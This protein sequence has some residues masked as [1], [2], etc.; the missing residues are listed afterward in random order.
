MSGSSSAAEYRSAYD[1]LLRRENIPG[2]R[3]ASGKR[4]RIRLGSAAPGGKT[5]TI[6][7]AQ[8]ITAHRGTHMTDSLHAC[9]FVPDGWHT[10][11]PRIVVHDARRLV[12]FLTQVF[13]ATAEFQD[14]R[15]CVVVLGDSMLMV[16]E[17]GVRRPTPAFLYIYVSDT[18]ATCRRAIDAGARVIEEPFDTPYGDRRCMVEDGWGNTWQVATHAAA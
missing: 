1:F 10:V 3:V 13:G 5:P 4:G 15:P 18:D 2:T 11:T 17:A 14:E 8:R 9:H 6:L 12:A 7:S 16:S